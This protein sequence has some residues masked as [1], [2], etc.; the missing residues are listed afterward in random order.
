LNEV[1]GEQNYEK[2]L[3]YAK[4]NPPDTTKPRGSITLVI[5]K[6]YGVEATRIVT[7]RIAVAEKYLEEFPDGKFRDRFNKMLS[8]D[9]NAI[10]KKDEALKISRQ[11]FNSS[12]IQNKINGAMKLGYNAHAS[13]KYDDAIEYYEFV[14]ENSE[15]LIIV[16]KF[17]FYTAVCFYELGDLEK[18]KQ[19]LNIVFQLSEK[20]ENKIVN[21]I[22]KIMLDYIDKFENK[23]QV[24]KRHFVFFVDEAN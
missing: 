11:L 16:I 17:N 20:T 12:K 14:Y 15:D 7:E 5:T 1:L 19:Y 24:P 9:Y 2:R 21:K 10:G 8:H 3:D 6:N 4:S 22:A 13:K 18:S 23:S